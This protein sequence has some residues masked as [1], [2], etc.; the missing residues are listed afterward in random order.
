M[1]RRAILL[2]TGGALALVAI[3]TPAQPA[4]P[5][6]IMFFHPGTEESTRQNFAAFR[7]QL[8]ELN[9]AEGRDLLIETQWGAGK[10]ERLDSTAA[11][12]VARKPEVI[13]T[14]T[15]AATAAFK[16]ATASIPIVF[17]SAGNPVEQGFVASLRRP[18]GNV[19]GVVVYPS[20][21]AGKIVEVARQAFPAARRLAILVHTPDPAHKFGLDGFLASAPRLG[22]EPIVVRVARIVDFDRAFS[23]LAARKADAVYLADVSFNFQNHEQLIE[24]ALR[25]R[26]PLLSD[27]HEITEKGGLLSYGVPR[28]DNYRRAA[29]LVD[30]ILHGAKPADLPVEQPERLQLVVNRKTAKAIGVE[31]SAVTLLR[32][33]RTIE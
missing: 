4:K 27:F 24:R 2:G 18:G 25:A 14:A 16:K 31:L 1:R 21:M 28:G 3:R 30:K 22:F 29:V 6:R 26:L 19:T 9:Y 33:D 15:S 10:T 11:E 8:K 7:A 5:R 12:I 13:V 23:E 20:E 17:A 32:A